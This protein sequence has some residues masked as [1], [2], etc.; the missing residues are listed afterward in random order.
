MNRFSQNRQDILDCLRSATTHPTAEW[1][2]TR[3]KPTHPSLSLATVYRNLTQLKKEGL[4]MSMGSVQGEERFDGATAPHTHILC[5]RCGKL[6]DVPGVSVPAPV[7]ES[8]RLATG[9]D[10]SDGGVQFSGLCADCQKRKE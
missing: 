6:A 4:I 2:Y 1:I 8:V 3:L 7:L 5:A 10:V 9:F